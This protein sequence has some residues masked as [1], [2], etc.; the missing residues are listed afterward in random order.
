M[1]GEMIILFYNLYRSWRG[2]KSPF[3]VPEVGGAK[4]GQDQSHMSSKTSEAKPKVR[5]GFTF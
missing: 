2:Q 1:P 5:R 4:L 3:A